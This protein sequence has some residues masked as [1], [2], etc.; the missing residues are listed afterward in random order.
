[1]T[2]L[3]FRTEKVSERITR[4]YAF[5]SELMYLVEG[6]N[7]AALIDS[8]SGIGFV[9]PLVEKLTD[10]PLKVLLTHGHVDHAMG[11][12]EFPAESVYISQED[13][14]IYRD[15]CTHEFRK[16]GLFLMGPKG[17][18][19][20]EADFTPIVSIENYNDLRDGDCFN[21]GG[22]S[23]EIYA[24]PGHT[25]GS[26]VMLI[27]EERTLILG[28]ACNGYTFVF[29]DYSLTIEEYRTSLI[30]LKDKLEGKYDKVLSSHGDGNLEHE[31]INDNI[32]LCEKIL[33]GTSDRIPME[34]RG[35][36][37]MVA[38]GAAKPGHGNIVYNPDRIYSCIYSSSY[39]QDSDTDI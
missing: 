26:M 16:E 36:T 20:T 27:P 1:M 7:E 15:H 34:F 21:L 17:K 6:D 19:I 4:I 22:V 39:L 29:Q 38:D 33:N 9:R 30:R 2:E 18:S 8:G 14:Y 24:C 10:K 3:N 5:S 35:D 11:A 13:A 32:L 12:S 23:I 28:D 31:V 25:K 37:G